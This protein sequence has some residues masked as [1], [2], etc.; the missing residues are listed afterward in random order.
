MDLLNNRQQE[1]LG[2]FSS[3]L[4]PAWVLFPFSVLEQGFATGLCFAI[5]GWLFPA[6]RSKQNPHP[7]QV[8]LGE[9]F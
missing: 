3:F 8:K 1:L 2:C 7:W 9:L 5:Q 6:R 4:P